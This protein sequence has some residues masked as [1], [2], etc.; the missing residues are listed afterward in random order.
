MS[1]L[2]PALE[3]AALDLGDLAEPLLVAAAG[4]LGAKPHPENFETQLLVH[5]PSAQG[6][7]VGVV[8]LAAHPGHE[9]VRAEGRPDARDLV[10]RHG[11]ADA[12]PADE[13]AALSLSRC[14]LF[15]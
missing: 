1:L 8:V 4:E 5:Q 3:E 2:V 13:E 11:H 15:P 12:G 6:E 9:R 7:D 14:H 10:G